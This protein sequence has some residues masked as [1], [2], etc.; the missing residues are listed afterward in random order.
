VQ[1]FL[2]STFVDTGGATSFASRNPLKDIQ[3]PRIRVCGSKSDAVKLGQAAGIAARS[4]NVDDLKIGVDTII[5][6][7]DR[8]IKD[9]AE[10]LD[11]SEKRIQ[12]LVNGETYY[13]KHR[14][15]NMFNALVHK[16]TDEMNTGKFYLRKLTKTDK[17]SQTLTLAVVTL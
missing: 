14:E 16:A 1:S 13:K 15:P 5:M 7:Q 3:P 11:V 6:S 2:N 4:Q 8:E 12:K 17:N 9:L 10:Q